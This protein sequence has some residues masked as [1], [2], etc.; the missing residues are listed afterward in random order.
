MLLNVDISD[1][2][3]SSETFDVVVVVIF[4]ASVAS[5]LFKVDTS[6]AVVSL[7]ALTLHWRQLPLQPQHQMCLMKQQR[8]IYRLWIALTAR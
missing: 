5:V 2:V 8:Q 6:V 3:V 1:I 4:V 7:M